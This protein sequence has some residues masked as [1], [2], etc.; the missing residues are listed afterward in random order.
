MRIELVFRQGLGHAGNAQFDSQRQQGFRM[1][2]AKHGGVPHVATGYCADFVE[3]VLDR[4]ACHPV[5]NAA[6]FREAWS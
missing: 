4:K 6:G 3:E 2:K 1:P 5:G